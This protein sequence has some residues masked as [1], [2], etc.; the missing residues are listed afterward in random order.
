MNRT[1]A[2]AWLITLGGQ[3]PAGHS[4]TLDRQSYSAIECRRDATPSRAA[5]T[6]DDA[7]A[8]DAEALRLAS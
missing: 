4:V 2:I 1:Q 7:A 5:H 3:L 8:P 6:C